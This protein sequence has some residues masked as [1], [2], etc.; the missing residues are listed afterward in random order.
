MA[1]RIDIIVI[2]KLAATDL[3]K[4][5]LQHGQLGMALAF[6]SIDVGGGEFHTVLEVMYVD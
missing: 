2:S 3:T 6:L 4:K 1:A 5:W